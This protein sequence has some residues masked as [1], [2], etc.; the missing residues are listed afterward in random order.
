MRIAAIL[1]SLLFTGCSQRE[2]V[3]VPAIEVGV[4]QEEAV[5]HEPIP[6]ARRKWHGEDKDPVLSGLARNV[7]RVGDPVEPL[8]KIHQHYEVFRHGEFVILHYDPTGFGGTSLTAKD[9]KLVF[10]GTSSCIYHDVFFDIMA[11]RDRKARGEGYADE[12]QKRR[13][14]RLALPAAVG[15]F[16]SYPWWYRMPQ[17]R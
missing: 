15:V 17:L 6:D 9:G 7:I 13:D 10:A 2:S 1:M 11:E 4:Q 8:I 3:A 5:R 14:L 12:L 16:G